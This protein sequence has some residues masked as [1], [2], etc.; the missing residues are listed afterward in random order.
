MGKPLRVTVDLSQLFAANAGIAQAVFPLVSQAVRAVAEEGAFRW[1]QRVMHAKLWEGEKAP[2]IESIQWKM[3]GPF[4]AEIFTDYK[5]A[6]PIETGRPAY[7]Q[8]VM[9]QTSKKTRVTKK[10][11]KYLIIP[12]R[13]NTPGSTALAPAMPQGV[14][15]KVKRISSSYLLKPGTIM[16]PT[17]VSGSGHVVAQHSYIWGASLKAGLAPKLQTHHKSDPYAGM[18]RFNTG[19]PGSKSSAYLTFRV[20]MEGSNGW[21]IPAKPGLYLAQKTSEDL[22]PLLEEVMGEALKPENLQLS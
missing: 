7:D 9:L 14:Y 6:G 1:K 12:F 19:T 8:K 16:P 22:Q 15:N 4:E 11:K 3:V 10:G 21:I 5:Q 20:M 13:H 2:Y 17:R 18:K